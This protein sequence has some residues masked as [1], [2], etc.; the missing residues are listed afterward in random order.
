[1]STRLAV[2]SLIAEIRAASEVTR[3]GPQYV[4]K[5]PPSVGEDLR[6]SLREYRQLAKQGIVTSVKILPVPGCAESE[7]QEGVCYPIVSTKCPHCLLMAAS[8]PHAA[9]AAIDRF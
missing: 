8:D 1:M 7:A 5:L 4:G 3:L 6:R 2:P 9:L